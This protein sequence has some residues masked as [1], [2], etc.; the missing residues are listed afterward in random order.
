MKERIL[1]VR[2][3]LK[4]WLQGKGYHEALKAIKF[5]ETYHKGIR[6]DGITPEFFHQI[7]M[8]YQF[9]TIHQLAIDPERVF[10]AIFLHDLME[11][12]PDQVNFGHFLDVF[13]N[14][15]RARVYYKDSIR[16]DKKS[17]EDTL[18]YFDGI[19]KCQVASLVKGLDR[20]HNFDTMTGV[21]TREKQV[22]YIN[23]C[24]NW[25]IPMLQ[26]AEDLYPE[27]S[28]LYRNLIGLL[29]VQIK[30]S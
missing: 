19:Q 27:Q 14:E 13:K 22:E 1:K 25:I 9:Q 23:E 12:Y 7:S 15:D 16:L 8:A 17:K 2:S 18:E 10:V 3:K 30:L 20:W 29:Y 11:D 24:E 4:G 26:E 21:F 6:K 5:G 28:M